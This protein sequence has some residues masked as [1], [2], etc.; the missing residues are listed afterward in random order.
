MNLL[1]DIPKPNFFAIRCEFPKPEVHC[2]TVKGKDQLKLSFF[3]IP[4]FHIQIPSLR[5]SLGI[6]ST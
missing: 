4:T 1:M 2:Y 5:L 3:C 6:F